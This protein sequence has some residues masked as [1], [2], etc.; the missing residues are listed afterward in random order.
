M[1]DAVDVVPYR[2]E[3]FFIQTHHPYK[4]HSWYLYIKNKC[5]S[6]GDVRP[7]LLWE[8]DVPFSWDCPFFVYI[9]C[10][11]LYGYPCGNK[12]PMGNTVAVAMFRTE[13][14]WVL[15]RTNTTKYV[16]SNS[17]GHKG[18]DAVTKCRCVARHFAIATNHE[19]AYRISSGRDRPL[20]TH[21]NIC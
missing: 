13:S 6:V 15:V 11:I 10:G 12:R 5:D 19:Y 7:C 2:H 20:Q 21:N 14:P 9:P 16:G 18:I 4:L 17:T 1:R 8:A 3:T